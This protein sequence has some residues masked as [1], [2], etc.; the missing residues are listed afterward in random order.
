[1]SN[2]EVDRYPVISGRAPATVKPSERMSEVNSYQ[3]VSS[4]SSPGVMLAPSLP[5]KIPGST[6]ANVATFAKEQTV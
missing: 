1:M 6:S 5:G 3:V 2:R 4:S